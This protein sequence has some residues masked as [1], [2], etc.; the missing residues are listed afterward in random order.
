MTFLEDFLKLLLKQIF[1]FQHQCTIFFSIML[2][3][4][5]SAP[6]KCKAVIEVKVQELRKKINLEKAWFLSQRN[7][8]NV[9]WFNP[10]FSR[11]S[12]TG[13]SYATLIMYT[14]TTGRIF[15]YIREGKKH[16]KKWC[17]CKAVWIRNHSTQTCFHLYKRNAIAVMVPTPLDLQLQLLGW[18]QMGLSPFRYA[19]IWLL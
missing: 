11:Q 16:Q 9:F 17:C 19:L 1:Q 15:V 12:L 5:C 8:K 7:H 18:V 2:L 6:L 10:C 14:Y 4:F 13:M 3:I